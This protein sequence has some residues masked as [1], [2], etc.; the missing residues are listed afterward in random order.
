M[1]L[2]FLK[3]FLK[4]PLLH[5]LVLGTALFGLFNL[6]DR[7]DP[8]APPKIVVSAARVSILADQF[9]RTWRRPPTG[10]ERE[11]LVEDYIRD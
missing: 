9:S 7:K 5:F 3:A 1:R 10:E 11:G 6:V 2:P 8:E 4:E